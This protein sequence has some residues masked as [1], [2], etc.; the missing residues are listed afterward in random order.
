MDAQ[1]SFTLYAQRR[2]RL[3]SQL[4]PGGI[5]IVPTAPEQQRPSRRPR[6]GQERDTGGDEEGERHQSVTSAGGMLAAPAVTMSFS[7]SPRTASRTS[8]RR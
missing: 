3:A 2:A 4:T 7:L 1:T 8:S 6:I 5:A